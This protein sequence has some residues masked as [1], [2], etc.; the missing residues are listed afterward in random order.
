VIEWLGRLRARWSERPPRLRPRRA[1]LRRLVAASLI[2]V[3][4]VLAVHLLAPPPARGV[5]V[6]VASRDIGAG[7][8]LSAGDLRTA[9]WS[10]DPSSSANGTDPAVL[11]GR[12]TAGPIPRGHPV[13]DTDVLGPGLLAG[14]AAGVVAVPVSVADPSAARLTRRGDH[15]D[16]LA[17]TAD[18]PI[19]AGAVVLAQPAA[20]DSDP[21]GWGSAADATGSTALILGV[22]VDQAQELARAQV[23]GTLTVALLP[24]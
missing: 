19:V 5:P 22:S 6:V 21:P 10:L 16:L 24:R 4:V 9:R 11:I 13:T 14:Q 1:G 8:T 17:A 20:G 18:A 23:A 3:G 7:Q 2:G 15:V 12:V